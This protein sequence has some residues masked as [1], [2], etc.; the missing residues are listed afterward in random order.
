MKII[1]VSSNNQSGGTTA[2]QINQ[3]NQFKKSKYK[4]AALIITGITLIA[5]II[6]ILQYLNITLV[7][8]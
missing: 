3:N 5:S 8:V 6:T 1:N 7:G 2:Y 4:I